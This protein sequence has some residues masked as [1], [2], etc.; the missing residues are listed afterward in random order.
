MGGISKMPEERV[1]RRLTTILAGDVAGYSRM[2]GE[3]ETGTLARLQ[4]HESQLI[5]PSVTEHQGRI[6]KRMGDGFL[7]EFGSVVEAVGCA[8]Q[9][10]RGMA[11]RNR[12]VAENRQMVYRIGVHLGDIIIDKDDIYGDG[13]NIAARLEGVAEAGGICVS[14]QAYDQVEGKLPLTFRKLGPQTLKNIAKPVEVFAIDAG[15]LSGSREAQ[16]SVAANLTQEVHYAR[17]PDG[18]RLA[19][20]KVGQGPPLVRAGHWLTHLE[21]DWENPLRRPALI[22]LA[23][24]HTLIRYDP[25]GTGLSDWDVDELSL[26]AWVSDLETVVDAA[27][28]ERFPLLGLSQSC[29]V[30]IIYAVRHPERVSHLV[31]YGG[32]ARGGDKRSPQEKEKRTAMATLMRMGW[33][34]N[35]A[36]F[37]QLFT[38]NMM[39]GATKE[40]AD[41]FNDLQ[42]RS[43]S[44]ECAVRYFETV[45]DFDV[46]A[47]L[48]KVSMPTLVMHVRGDLQQP[49]EAGRQMAAGIARARF[50]ALQGQN[51]MLLPGEPAA[52]RFQEELELFLTQ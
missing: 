45:G 23:K 18:V 9:I 4:A 39:P 51:H 52:A 12:S 34:A 27:G 16:T 47:L 41:S 26:D 29:A 44:P 3:D 2:M 28:L 40:Q 20:A 38:S 37:R 5:A 42:R 19:W 14:R 36:G 33:G 11:A 46:T 6:V 35:D 10:Q 22:N 21:Y 1:E 31:L 13:V 24:G 30:S 43:T 32:F 7:A 48:A 50:V 8:A 49:F 17:A 15:T 25:R